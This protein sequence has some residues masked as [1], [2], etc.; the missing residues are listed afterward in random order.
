VD[1][2][3][4]AHSVLR[5]DAEVYVQDDNHERFLYDFVAA[6]I[7]VMNAERFDP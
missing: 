3:F 6:W 1:L 4:G 5:A 7:I 2:A